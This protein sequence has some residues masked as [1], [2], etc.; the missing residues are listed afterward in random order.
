L[1]LQKYQLFSFGKLIYKREKHAY[2]V[3]FQ[4]RLSLITTVSI[5][6]ILYILK[7]KG[8]NPCYTPALSLKTGS[9]WLLFNANSIL[10]W[11]QVK[12]MIKSALYHYTKTLWFIFI[13]LAQWNNRPWVDM[14]LHSDTL[15]WF[16]ANQ[17]LLLLLNAVCFAEKQR[18]PIW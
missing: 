16:W 4:Q 17:F 2:C 1:K 7:I 10:W 18:T 13:V 12:M 15:S 5:H 3:N 14:S 9:Q 11:E 6:C 8:D